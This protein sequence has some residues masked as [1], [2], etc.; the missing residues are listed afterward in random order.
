MLVTALLLVGLFAA[1]VLAQTATSPP[2]VTNQ[3]PDQTLTIAATAGDTA[4]VTVSLTDVDGDGTADDPAFTDTTDTAGTADATLVYTAATYDRDIVS[5]AGLGEQTQTATDWW[6]ALGDRADDPAT[7]GVDETLNNADC[8][9]KAM[10]LGFTVDVGRTDDDNDNSP[11]DA[12]NATASGLCLDSGGISSTEIH[13][14]TTGANALVAVVA[15]AETIAAAFHWDMLSGPEMV[16]I[17]R[18]AGASGNYAHNFGG[19]S[20]A[21]KI[22]V[23]AWFGAENVLARGT[24]SITL[25]HDGINGTDT[26]ADPEGKAGSTT[27]V[28]KASDVQGRLIPPGDGSG[29]VGQSFTVNAN[30]TATG[31]ISEFVAAADATS[32][33]T[34]TSCVIGLA[35]GAGVAFVD[36]GDDPD[37]YDLTVGT[38]A[39][40]NIAQVIADVGVATLS[41]H[42]QK[43]E[44]IVRGDNRFETSRQL[45]ATNDAERRTAN[46]AIKSGST[47]TR[48]EVI[49]LSLQVNEL[50]NVGPNN[51][52]IALKVTVVEGG[53][54]PMIDT[55]ALDA[56]FASDPAQVTEHMAGDENVGTAGLPINFGDYVTS[57]ARVTYSIVASGHASNPININSSSGQ[58]TLNDPS[59]GVNYDFGETP[60]NSI[61][62]TLTADDGARS[63]TYSFDVEI[64]TNKPVAR[65]LA[66]SDGPVALS[67]GAMLTSLIEEDL[68]GD[69]PETEMGPVARI[70]V[71]TTGNGIP[72]DARGV[73]VVEVAELLDPTPFD[74]SELDVIGVATQFSSPLDVDGQTIELDYVP[75]AQPTSYVLT[76]IGT[77]TID[78]DYAN[79]DPPVADAQIKLVITVNVKEPPTVKT[80]RLPDISVA[81]NSTGIIPG[82]AGQYSAPAG[83]GYDPKYDYVSGTGHADLE[84]EDDAGS[85]IGSVFSVNSDT[86]EVSIKTTFDGAAYSG[87][88]YEMDPRTNDLTIMVRDGDVRLGALLAI[89][90]VTVNVSDV[91]EAPEFADATMSL[92]AKENA[93]DGEDIGSPIMATDVDAGQTLTYTIKENT[94]ADANNNVPFQV[95]ASNGA[96][97][98]QKMGADNL[99]LSPAYTATLVATDDGNPAM[100]DELT[101]TITVGD[102]NDAPS[103]AA[104]TQLEVTIPEDLAVGQNVLSADTDG[105][106]DADGMF[107][108]SDPDNNTLKFLVENA[109]DS[110]VFHLDETTGAL[111]LL[112]ALDFETTREYELDI[113]VEDV[114]GEGQDALEDR[115]ELKIHITDVNDNKPIFKVGNL[116]PTETVQE[117]SAYGT[118]IATYVAE[119]A[120]GTS[121]N[122]TI[123]YSL[124]G[125]DAKSF[126]I[127]SETGVLT[128]LAS[129]DFDSESG[130][131]TPCDGNACQVTVV[132]TDGGTPAM[133]SN[134]EADV[135]GSG[136]VDLTITLVDAADSVSGFSIS[137]AN[138]IANISSDGDDALTALSDA[139]MTRSSA[140]PESPAD[141][142]AT[143]G[144][145]PANFVTADWGNWGT[146]LRIEVT[147]ESPDPDCG[148]GNQCVFLG[149]D[150]DSSDESIRLM[151]YRSSDQENLFIA[152]V[153]LVRRETGGT[154]GVVPV[155]MHSDGTGVARLIVDEEDDVEIRLIE[156]NAAGEFVDSKVAPTG[157]E[158]ENERPEFTNFMPEH[159]AAFDDGD[160]EYTFT[161]TDTVSGIPEPEDL[162]DGNGD[163]DY[164]PLVALISD[165]QCQLED[166]APAVKG[167]TMYP[168]AGNSVWC[169]SEPTIWAV[170]DDRDFDEVD[171]GFEVDTKIVLDENDHHYVT[172]I[173]CDAAGNC[174]LYTPDN[175][176]V[177]EAFAQIT[178]DT[179]DPEIY[180]ARTGIMWDATD[181]EL[182]KN[183]PTWIQVIFTDLSVIDEDSVEADDFVVK[184]HTVKDAKRYGDDADGDAARLAEDGTDPGNQN[185]WRSIFLEL[186]DEL[187]PDEEPNVS[188]VPNGISDKAGNEQ[189]DG[190]KD[191]K[192]Y[193]APSFTV[194]SIVSPRTPDAGMDD[195]L[196]GEDDEVVITLMS[197][198]R[199]QETRPKV[200]VTY[201]NASEVFT[202][203]K[204]DTCDDEGNDDGYR[205]RGE[206]VNNRDCQDADAAQGGTLGQTIAK[207]S[208]TEW[209][210]IV[211]EPESTGY[212]NIYIE[213]TDR[214]EQKNRGDEGVAPGDLVTDFFERDGDV[215][216][217]DAHFFQGD[218][219]IAFPAV[220]VSG[221]RIEDT[222]PAVEFKSPLFVELNF[223]ETY[224]D[225]C[226]GETPGSDDH[227]AKCFAE[228]NEYAK[229]SFDSVTVTS[230]LLNGEDITDMVR[231]TDDETF[232]VSISGIEIGD[233]EIEIQAVDKAGNDLAKTLSVEFEVEERD[234][235]SQRLNPGWNLVSIPGEPADSDISTVF[236]SDM[237]VRTV[238]TYNPII[239]G[240]WMVA[241]RESA[242]AEWQGDLK[243]ITARQGYWVLSDAIQDWDVSI[244]RLAGGAVG[245]GTPIQ[246]PVIALYAGW[247]LVPVIDVT[248]DFAGGGISATAYLQSLDD[249]LDLARVLGFDTITNK[250]DTVMAP[251][252]GTS[253]RL[254]FGSAYWVFVRQ[255]A[256]LVPGN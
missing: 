96:A 80:I 64:V 79:A 46:I 152:A 190:D 134:Y 56:H 26:E 85:V 10:R 135:A 88:N 121:P 250:W 146:V 41:P 174:A 3:I 173:V 60:D 72:Q 40:G 129:L 111:T 70:T 159:E 120:D 220:W 197:D 212:Y 184:G 39:T 223:T 157:V 113:K 208:N 107:N 210:I 226:E 168:Y 240:G 122:N 153:M 239:P 194:V 136:H 116:S 232:L 201:V 147:H 179:E 158:V 105:D 245:S 140:V 131:N 126:E 125:P 93:N 166:P 87:L 49:D 181:E 7:D 34:D 103:F 8:S 109:T 12:D 233:H 124:R 75:D 18:G 67:T 248:G 192:D 22:Q 55:A 139:K 151:A 170:T 186:E 206:I 68:D 234:D 182:D 23:L 211:K 43:L 162:P 15:N 20:H 227:K 253:E 229:D 2:S 115:T 59:T 14:A 228:S 106:V 254:D 4:D 62:Y 50:G 193:I 138:P 187:A 6:D 38:D 58:V 1:A 142:P 191:A 252:S 44:I 13:E 25:D 156:K 221:T 256:S 172:F 100:S 176:E 97:Q 74:A 16:A 27:V 37:R 90:N 21:Q 17:A 205:V 76:E 141:L 118:I 31:D 164:M 89:M 117:N 51:E 52:R 177:E 127:D 204:R 237:E 65:T 119:D 200:T 148:N 207:V 137:K 175:N 133:S 54:A 112:K 19:L 91:N 183:N 189:D 53:E 36:G 163:S 236:G 238:Y 244:P 28:V 161:I 249:G 35:N 231:T 94:D 42:H 199:I 224:L 30:L 180:E 5:V 48:D 45:P 169:K 123:T 108:A 47:L 243:E 251:E 230:F 203:V 66:A 247:N 132:A 217:D 86:G 77:I 130:Q 101:L 144:D 235:F 83:S 149:L 32:C 241:V 185:T 188:V 128:T 246:P 11:A 145:A 255:A 110:T 202:A 154:N 114:P 178:V 171:D 9:A 69:G 24:G 214:S 63:A 29:T 165:G 71:G 84:R 102:V 98:V 104:D 222:E 167:Y 143:V 61:A 225:G 81:E 216:T 209:T 215:N 57:D 99:R 92:N 95:A 196:A 195:Q 160:V 78:D 218:R 198:E 242:D 150:A 82:T 33:T 219:N 73:A 213:G 155:Y